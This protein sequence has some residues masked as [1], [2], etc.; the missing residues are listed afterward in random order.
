MPLTPCAMRRRIAALWKS[1]R[2]MTVT[3]LSASPSGTMAP[4]FLRQLAADFSSNSLLQRMKA[5]EWALPL[6]AQSSRRMAERFRLKMQREAA[7]VFIFVCQLLKRPTMI[8]PAA[9]VFV[10][11]DDESVRKSLRR[12]LDA[13]H[14]KTEVFESASEFLSRSAYQGPSCV[15]V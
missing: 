9:T 10:I 11:D 12:L 1:L 5:W 14:Y 2:I 6:C 7:R 3:A 13:A 8:S 15:I 4:G